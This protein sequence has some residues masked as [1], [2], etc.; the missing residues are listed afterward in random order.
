M[1]IVFL[2]TEIAE[3]FLSCLRDLKKISGG[4]IDVVRWPIN[5]EAPFKFEETEGLRFHERKDYNTPQLLSLVD[6]LKPDILFCSGWVDDGYIEVAKRMHRKGVPVVCGM[7]NPWKGTFRQ[8][9]ARLVSRFTIK[10]YFDYIWVPGRPQTDFAKRIGFSDEQILKGYYSANVDFF[11]AVYNRFLS[12]KKGAYPHR[13]L[14]LGRYVEQ[15]GINDLWE[16][17]LT[18]TSSTETDWELWCIGTGLLFEE[19]PKHPKIRHIGFV[20]PSDL[21]EYIGDS[22]VFVLPSHYEPWGVVV[23]ELASAGLPMICSDKVGAATAFLNEGKN[24]YLFPSGSASA[25]KDAM[26]KM[27]RLSHSQLLNMADCSN[28][29]AN[30]ITPRKWSE[31]LLSVSSK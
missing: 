5:S 16:A 31:T 26:L 9:I 14:Y 12:T 13:F 4:N 23:H 11:N 25:L 6:S 7:D 19:A 28:K 30:R 8:Q 24:G 27:T 22:G 15:K 10:R 29:I 1:N 21:P 3:Y 2:Y 17:F 18:L 20:Q